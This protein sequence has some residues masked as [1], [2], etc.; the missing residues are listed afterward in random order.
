MR[1]LHTLY[2]IARLPTYKDLYGTSPNTLNVC[3]CF[4]QIGPNLSNTYDIIK[5]LITDHFGGK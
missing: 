3:F 5:Y 1:L 2:N 4:N